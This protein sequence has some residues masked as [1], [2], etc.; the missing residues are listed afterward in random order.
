MQSHSQA[1]EVLANPIP[2]A[3]R[4]LGIGRTFLYS[5]IGDGTIKSFK[6]GART[7]IPESE[8]VRFIA[9]KMQGGES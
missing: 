4:R 7:L 8:L 2:E 6:V 3:C 1:G 5:L 9:N